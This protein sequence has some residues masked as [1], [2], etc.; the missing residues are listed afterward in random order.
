M[1][2][3]E[4]PF[5]PALEVSRSSYV[6]ILDKVRNTILNWSLKLEAD[7]ILGEGLT[8]SQQ[9]KKTAAEKEPELRP[10]VTVYVNNN[11]AAGKMEKS[12]VQQASPQGEMYFDPDEGSE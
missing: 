10:L 4:F 9:E 6:A 2:G 12:A 3:M 5:R 8:F 7:G 1:R 11:V